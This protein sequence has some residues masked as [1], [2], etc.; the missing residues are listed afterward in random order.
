[1]RACMRGSVRASERACVRVCVCCFSSLK[2]ADSFS[3]NAD[4]ASGK[5]ICV[6]ISSISSFLQSG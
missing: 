3:Q 1:M 5:G 2:L 6:F 4:L